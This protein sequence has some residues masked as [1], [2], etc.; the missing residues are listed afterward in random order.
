M[1]AKIFTGIGTPLS[2]TRNAFRDIR[3]LIFLSQKDIREYWY[4]CT[5]YVVNTFWGRGLFNT[6]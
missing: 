1:Y 6:N 3:L 5:C 2:A 4:T